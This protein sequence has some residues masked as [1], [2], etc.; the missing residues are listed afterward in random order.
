MSHKQS[1][2]ESEEERGKPKESEGER[3]S[4]KTMCATCAR[5]ARCDP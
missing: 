2:A 3:R 4:A 5:A 1:D